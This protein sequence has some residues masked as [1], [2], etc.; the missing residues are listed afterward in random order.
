MIVVGLRAQAPARGGAAAAGVVSAAQRFLSML[1]EKQKS[2]ASFSFNDPIKPGWH[3]LPPQMNTRAGVRYSELTPEQRDAGTAVLRAVL[4][5]YGYQKVQDILAADKYLGEE[6][7][8]GF[9]TGPDAYMLAIFGTP[10]PTEPWGVQFNGHHL[11]VNVSIVGSQNVLAPTL[12]AAYPNIYQ[13]D[14]KTIFVLADE[15]NRALKLVQSLDQTQRAKAV[16]PMQIWDFLLGPGHDGETIQPEGLKGSEMTPSQ[17][18]M[19]L[20]VAAAW[21]NIVND[22]TAKAKLA[23]VRAALADTYFLWS[24]DLTRPGYAYFRVQGPTVHIEYSP[25]TVGGPGS[26]RGRGAARGDVAARGDGARGRGRA[27]IP[28]GERQLDATHVHTVYR[29]FTND[30]AKKFV[31]A[32]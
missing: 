26:A 28:P 11:G 8:V 29:D 1:D 21:V 16:A 24:G 7:G 30:Y 13:K 12:T 10:S 25:Q 14:G 2:V 27:A 4:S 3:N 5:P 32:R 15:A 17:R 31:A 18:E 6:M 20:D 9:P 22:A 19:M 23:E